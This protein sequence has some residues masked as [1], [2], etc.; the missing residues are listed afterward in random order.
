MGAKRHCG[1]EAETCRLNGMSL[2]RCMKG[3]GVRSVSL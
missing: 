1:D 2:S 3:R